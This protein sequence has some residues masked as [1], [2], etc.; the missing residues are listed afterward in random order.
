MYKTANHLQL[1]GFVGGADFDRKAVD[2]ILEK[3]RGKQ[4][5]V[6]IDSTGGYLATTLGSNYTV[7]DQYFRWVIIH[8]FEKHGWAVE[9]V[10]LG[11]PM[12]H[13]EKYL[14]INLGF[15]GK[16]RLMPFFNRFNNEELI[17]AIQTAGVSRERN[18]FRKDKSGEKLT[19]LAECLS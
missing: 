2:N 6:L 5:N 12:P 7:K 15:S 11:N 16:L 18:G 19:I 14:L 9:P 17:L 8:E 1:K 13:H 4:V 10:Y 3:N